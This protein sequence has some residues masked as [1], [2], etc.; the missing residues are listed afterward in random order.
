MALINCPECGKYGVS[1]DDGTCPSCG[2]HMK[3]YIKKYIAKIE[4]EK[5]IF[6]KRDDDERREEEERKLGYRYIL[7][8]FGPSRINHQCPGCTEKFETKR[9]A[10]WAGN[11]SKDCLYD[12]T[13][14]CLKMT[15]KKVAPTGEEIIIK[16]FRY[17]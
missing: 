15:I 14:T 8:R 2:L 10:E 16:V 3:E 12:Q 9:D 11:R 6:K 13:G 1:Y 7:E 17:D 4:K 5:N